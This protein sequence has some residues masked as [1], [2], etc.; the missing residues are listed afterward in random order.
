MPWISD[1]CPIH[2][3]FNLDGIG[4]G[5]KNTTNTL[6]DIPPQFIWDIISRE[7]YT[8]N[9]KSNDISERI[10][11]LVNSDN[12]NSI[13]IAKE[14]TDILMI[15]AR[16]CRIK[17]KSKMKE[18]NI[19]QN[20][21]HSG[22]WF[23]KECMK[24]KNQISIEGKI[25][26]QNPSKQNSRATLFQLKR[27]FRKMVKRKKRAHKQEILNQMTTKREEKNQ[28]EFWKLLDKFK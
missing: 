3:N 11:S 26:K 5:C 13:D 28:K 16:A 25:L 1:H 22:P 19:R 15:N 27:V 4:A 9:L 24:I 21:Y 14:I 2:T 17:T 20:A 7:R 8:E 23:D 12:N 10:N 6:T 18:C